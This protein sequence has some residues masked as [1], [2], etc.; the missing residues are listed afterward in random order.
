[1]R[2]RAARAGLLRLRGRGTRLRAR[3]RGRELRRGRRE[4][5]EERGEEGDER[6]RGEEQEATEHGQGPRRG[7]GS[8]RSRNVDLPCCADDENDVSEKMLDASGFI[9]VSI[10]ACW[11]S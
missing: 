10:V 7:G 3:Q 6:L 4:R 8:G 5:G 2:E 11:Q 9:G 1:V